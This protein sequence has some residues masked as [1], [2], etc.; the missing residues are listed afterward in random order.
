MLHLTILP[1]TH[2][3]HLE[4]KRRNVVEVLCLSDVDVDRV[5]IDHINYPPRIYR[6][7]G[8]WFVGISGDTSIEDVSR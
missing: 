7:L 5:V 8:G 4:L 1:L 3:L 6:G 2:K